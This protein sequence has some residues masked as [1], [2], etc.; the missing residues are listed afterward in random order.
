MFDPRVGML[1][2]LFMVAPVAAWAHA[3]LTTSNPA[4]DATVSAPTEVSLRFT[5]PLEKS[6]SSVEVHNTNGQRVDD[7]KLRPA[8]DAT[9]LAVGLPKLPPGRYQVIWHATSVDTHRTVG[10]FAF[11]VAP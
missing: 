5:Q 3:H 8:D 9:A 7:G 10:S 2:V 6:F 11:T 1:A 4:E